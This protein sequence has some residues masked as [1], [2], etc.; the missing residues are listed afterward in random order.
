MNLP[1]IVYVRRTAPGC[2]LM[3]DS[4]FEPGMLVNQNLFFLI[5]QAMVSLAISIA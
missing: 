4:I 5:Y 1:L 3:L 2:T